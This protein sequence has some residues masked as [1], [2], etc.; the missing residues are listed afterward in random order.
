MKKMT[1]QEKKEFNE[2][3]DY[4]KTDILEYKDK[5]LPKQLILRIKGLSEGKFMAN[6]KVKPLGYYSYN[7]ILLTFKF[8]KFDI[9]NGLRVNRD[10]FKNELH[11]INYIMVIIERN[12]NDIVDRLSR[13]NKSKIKGREVKVIEN[14]NKA[15]YKP[16]TK[17]IK[18]TRLNDLW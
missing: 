3:Y 12:I 9:I 13:M 16:K 4:I 5:V 14:E 10:N 6:T 1:D 18:N 11:K 8:C 7:T 2:L 17:E 15:Q